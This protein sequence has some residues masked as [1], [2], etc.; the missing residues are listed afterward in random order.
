MVETIEEAIEWI[1]GRLPFGIRPGLERVEALLA[2]VDHPEKKLKMIH[3][4]GTNGKGSTVSYLSQMLQEVGLNVGTFTSPYIE[5]FNERIALNGRYIPDEDLL[6]LVQKYQPLVA[7]L[8]QQEAVSGITEFEL[9]TVMGL[10]Y[11]YSQKVD[12]AI[13]E[14]GLGGLLDSTNVIQPV[15][16]GITTIGLD[17]TDI[18]GETLAE[19]ASQK[20]G[21]I[22]PNT[23]LVTGNIVEEARTVIQ[24]RAKTLDAPIRLY[25]ADYQV[26]NPKPDPLWGERFDFY[27]E[28]GKLKDLKTPLLGAHQVENAG[29][30]IE[31]FYTYC[32]L[33]DLPVFP[34]MIRKG[35]AKTAWPARMER[36][37]EEPLVIL[38]GAHNVHAMQRL[39]ENMQKTF[40]N[41]R[42]YILFSALETKDIQQ[43]LQALCHIPKSEIVLTTFDNPRAIQLKKHYE[44]TNPLKITIA[45][46][47]KFGLAD[48]LEKS[49]PED[50]ILITG[51]LYF[52]SEIRQYLLSL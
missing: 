31:L 22:K 6:Q 24:A 17:H 33:N 25:G 12:V 51:S 39:V 18:L 36:I 47:W 15:L 48:L 8:D 13:I 21:I 52:V 41:R 23:P 38:D 3:L 50:V 11:F 5:V 32:K 7:I 30:A 44:E 10:D 4:A 26:A 40:A 29:L 1:H 2:L 42:I 46:S 45:S 27:N 16:T 9:L 14:V 28:S 43:M 49:T 35:L 37:Q 19:V 34:E 20:A